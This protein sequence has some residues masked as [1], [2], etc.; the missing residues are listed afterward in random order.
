MRGE[1]T[2]ADERI[3]VGEGVGLVVLGAEGIGWLVEAGL[4]RRRRSDKCRVGELD[5][6]RKGKGTVYQVRLLRDREEAHL[7][8]DLLA[9]ILCAIYLL[10]LVHGLLD[11]LRLL[12]QLADYAR[13]PLGL[14]LQLK[15]SPS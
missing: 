12:G 6:R 1:D 13:I 9:G 4:G 15:F 7:L 8:F 10:Q 3:R 5:T 2:S 14:P 11:G